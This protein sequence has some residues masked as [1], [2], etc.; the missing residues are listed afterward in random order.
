MATLFVGL[1]VP[2]LIALTIARIVV[3][4]G[5]GESTLQAL[6]ISFPVVPF[7]GLPVLGTIFGTQAAN[8]TVV[9]SGLVTNLLILPVSIV[10]LTIAMA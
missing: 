3:R 7:I 10:L 6:A 1:A 9:I 5:L 4:R 8:K 2:F